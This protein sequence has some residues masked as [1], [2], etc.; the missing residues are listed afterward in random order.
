VIKPS[1][2]HIWRSF[3][4]A[5]AQYACSSCPE[6]LQLLPSMLAAAVMYAC[7]SSSV[8]LQQLP[9]MLAPAAVSYACSCCPVCL[10]Q[11]PYTARAMAQPQLPQSLVGACLGNSSSSSH[12]GPALGVQDCV[13]HGHGPLQDHGSVACASFLEASPPNLWLA[14]VQDC[15]RHPLMQRGQGSRAGSVASI[16]RLQVRLQVKLQGSCGQWHGEQQH[17]V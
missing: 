6:C 13:G 2:S 10:Q 3:L 12:V 5:S 1:G 7:S 4:A 11:L 17:H 14:T 8:C 15:D 16:V 9:S